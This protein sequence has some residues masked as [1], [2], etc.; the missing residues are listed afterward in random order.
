MNDQNK[1]ANGPEMN[2][3]D[4]HGLGVASLVLGII[5]VVSSCVPILGLPTG[6]VGLIL[7]LSA[8]KRGEGGMA[9]AGVVLSI[10]AIV[11]AVISMVIGGYEAGQNQAVTDTANSA[12]QLL[13]WK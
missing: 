5:G 2:G 10:I 8:K 1:P 6:I 9:V 7:G 4:G 3:E 11:L 12:T 13:M